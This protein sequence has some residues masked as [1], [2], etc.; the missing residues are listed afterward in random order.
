MTQQGVRWTAEQVLALAPDVSSRRA[1]SRLGVAG[2]WSATGANEGAVWGL[3][4]GSGSKPYQTMVALHGLAT[5]SGPG[6]KCSCPSRKFPCKHALGLLLLW[7]VDERAVPQGEKP[8]EWVDEWLEGRRRRAEGKPP[9]RIAPSRADGL[10]GPGGS[11][12]TDRAA[13]SRRAERRAERMV[14]GASELEQRLIDLLRGGLASADRAGYATWDEMAARMVDAQAPGLAAR[15]REL[16]TVV[17]SGGGE[18]PGRLLAE[19]ALLHLLNQGFLGVDRLPDPLAA[20][21]RARVGVTTDAA[22]L[23]AAEEA[24]VRDQWLVL[25]R[26]DSED[27]RL[28]TR[29]TW[30]HGQASGRAALLL[31]FGAAGRAPELALPTGLSLDAVLAYYPGARPLRAA[32]GEQFAPPAPGVVPPGSAVGPAL[33][34]YGD[35]LRHD[36]WLESWPVVLS[37]VVPIPGADRWQVAD[38]HD[39]AALPVDP[40]CLGRTGLWRLVAVSGGRPLTVFGECGHRGF[41][42]LTAWSPDTAEAI[43]L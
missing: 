32:L 36:P 18:W 33:A 31:S 24:A 40:R 11:R 6:Y 7:S 43:P 8:P 22:E 12:A 19:C 37:G 20:T 23:L 30:L 10:N 15:V 39:D 42:P 25:G 17:G 35:A 5:G 2:P 1:G 34:A 9:E 4:K 14:A 21:V 16:G 29:R 27:G 28:T 3:C 41:N 26:Q 13:A 38:A